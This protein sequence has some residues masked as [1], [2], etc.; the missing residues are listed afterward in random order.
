MSVRTA[1]TRILAAAAIPVVAG[2]AVAGAAAVLPSAQAAARGAARP[3]ALHQTGRVALGTTSDIFKNAFTESPDGKLFYSRGSVVYVV[4]GTAKPA[5]ALH[6]RGQVMALAANGS[7]LFVLTG[8]RVTEYSRS[9][10]AA[11]RHWTLSSP[12]TPITAAGLLSVGTTLWAW[13]DWATDS[14]GFEYA[15]LSRIVTTSSAVHV[16]DKKAYPADMAANAS[17]LYYQDVRGVADINSLVH[18]TPAGVVHA[19]SLTNVDAPAALW[20]GRLD[21]L[22]FHGGH[23]NL[24]SYNPA[25]LARASS[26]HVSSDDRNIAG[27]S[28]GLLVLS[29]PCSGVACASATVSELSTSGL[30]TGAVSVPDAAM[31]LP[32]PGA[33]VIEDAGGHMFLVRFGS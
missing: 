27:T 33:A 17:G 16:V 2:L 19:R 4:T 31:L 12:V 13:T 3:A 8:L 1:R 22:S 9:N 25:T 7:G 26:A 28:I 6:A 32:G 29:E 14:S 23:Q 30:T 5:V 21:L 10:G 11:V 24:D 18:V 15:N 20:A